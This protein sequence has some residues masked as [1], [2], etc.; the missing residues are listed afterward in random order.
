MRTI[1]T[2][3][4]K[5]EE[6]TK[7]AQQ[8][9]IENYRNNYLNNDFIYDD[10]YNTVKAFNAAFGTKEGSRSWLDINTNHI[11]DYILELSGFRLQ[12]YL[13]NNFGNTLFKNKY[14]KHG[15]TVKNR[16]PFHPMQQQ[17]ILNSGPN[18]GKFMISYYSNLKKDNLCVLTGVCYDEDILQPIYNFLQKR[19]FSNCTIN[20]YHL[21]NN[22][23]E[24]LKKSIE[25]EVDF[26]NLDECI[27]EEILENYYEF[28]KDGKQ[29]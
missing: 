12:K 24:S 8:I 6:L 26:R 14:L 27:E 13:I 10:A 15:A 28:T 16:K 5:F 11:E 21:L 22:C 29:F 23:F 7:D 1:R 4:Y 25:N 3:I 20:F 17:S 9:A 18:K 19:D 2:K